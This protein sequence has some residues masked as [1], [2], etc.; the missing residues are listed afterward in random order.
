MISAIVNELKMRAKEYNTEL[1]E[2]IYLGGGTPSIL[3]KNEVST[4]IDTAKENYKLSADFE[5]TLECNPDDCSEENLKFWRSIG[6]NR[7]SIGIQSL[8]EKQLD[9][10]N[11]AHNSN[12]S[13]KAVMLAHACGFENI[14][15]DLIYGLPDLS[16]ERWKETIQIVAKL[17]INHI[18]AYCLTVEEKTPLASWVKT[19]KIHP[20]TNF[21]QSE[22]FITLID[23]LE[24]FGFEQYEISN[25][26]RNHAYSRHNTAYWQNKKYLGIGPSA[27]GFDGET[28][29][30]NIANNQTYMKSIEQRILPQE[31]ECL[32]NHDRFNE[33]IMVGLRTKWGVSLSELKTYLD[34]DNEWLNQVKTFQNEG[35][36]L[37]SEDDLILTEAGKLQAD[38]IASDLFKLS[39]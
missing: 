39:N 31:T 23:S 17:P 14:T 36:L 21:E 20:S 32:T 3:K 29:Y 25:F 15:V 7:L 5:L 24:S 26:A 33:R 10:M 11:R 12:E 8:E 6:F 2:T 13:I 30:W 34:L 18:S 9:W 37:V 27:H 22:Q 19:G 35:L 4:I 16:I 28:R 1:V 38:A